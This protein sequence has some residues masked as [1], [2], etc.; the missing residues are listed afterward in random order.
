MEKDL[1]S[2]GWLPPDTED[3]LQVAFR[4]IQ[5]A[6]KNKT[7]TMDLEIR[8]LKSV[9]NEKQSSIQSLEKRLSALELELLESRQRT[10]N[11][12]DENKQL[13]QTV[14]KLRKD[15]SRLDSLKKVLMTSLSDEQGQ[16]EDIVSPYKSAPSYQDRHFV[17]EQL[18]TAA[19]LTVHEL[20]LGGGHTDS[21]RE[22]ERPKSRTE[23]LLAQI[24]RNIGSASKRLTESPAGNGNFVSHGDHRRGS[25]PHPG[26]SA[27]DKQYSFTPGQAS[28]HYPGSEVK[29]SASRF[30][31]SP[32]H[33]SQSSSSSV[34]GKQFFRQA[35][36]KLSYE[37]FNDFL[38]NIKRLNNHLQTRDETLEYARQIFGPDNT[39]LF[40]D[41]K[42][43]LTKHG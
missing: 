24:D 31:T 14:R 39:D 26:T 36:A 15:Q 33:E 25:P 9:V 42:S 23:A 29:P 1:G 22:Q 40:R 5:S 16:E 11:L 32:P 6:Y 30:D 2:L 27:A 43:L 38:A 7:Q 17:E 10:Q 41:F 13:V 21:D 37:K 34:D 12:L 3:Q 20:N 35:R 8:S 4:I 19:P 18:Y 28:Q